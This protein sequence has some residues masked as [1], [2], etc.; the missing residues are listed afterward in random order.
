MKSWAADLKSPIPM[1][2][3]LA[4]AETHSAPLTAP[5][6]KVKAA[7]AAVIRIILLEE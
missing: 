7:A 5:A 2:S 4:A 1:Q 3:P 6:A